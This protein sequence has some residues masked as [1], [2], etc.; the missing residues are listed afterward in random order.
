MDDFK[1]GIA[2]LRIPI[3]HRRTIRTTDLLDRLFIEE[4]R[5]LKIIS[6]ALGEKAVLMLMCGAMIRAAE[7]CRA[8][9]I[10]E[11]ERRQMHAFREELDHQ[12][13]VPNTL[14]AKTSALAPQDK[15]SNPVR[16]SPA[17]LAAALP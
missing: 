1:A 2:Q 11:L 8:I 3:T 4:R 14:D 10:S 6:N 13:K 12:Y 9:R 7:R 5:R 17:A 15:I 16:T